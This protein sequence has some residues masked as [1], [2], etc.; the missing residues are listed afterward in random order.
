MAGIEFINSSQLY[1]LLNDEDI[2]GKPLAAD[3]RN[4]LLLDARSYK[5]FDAGHILLA[6]HA[7][8]NDGFFVKPAFKK[9]IISLG[10]SKYKYYFKSS[11]LQIDCITNIIVYDD[12]GEADD[13]RSEVKDDKFIKLF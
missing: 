6:E 3:E 7:K 1:N 9:V 13:S 2:N 10:I 11:F 5:R 8:R 12:L 4:F